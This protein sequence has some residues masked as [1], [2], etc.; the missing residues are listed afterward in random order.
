MLPTWRQIPSVLFLGATGV[1]LYSF[2]F[3][4]GLETITAGRAAL[5]VACIPVCIAAVSAIFYKESFGAVRIAGTLL[6]L[7]G[8]AMVISDGSPLELIRGGIRKGDLYILGC[9]ASWTAYSLGGK[10]TM[11]TLSPLYSVTWSCVFG[12]LLLLPAA[13][14]SGLTHEAMAATPLDWL[15]IVYLGVLATGLAYCWY[16]AAIQSLGAS[17]AGIFIN[18]VPVF[19]V[20]LGFLLLAE[21]IHLSLLVGGM[22]VVGGVWLTNRP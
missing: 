9:V 22:M 5:I 10:A 11:R 8:V 19:A 12:A 14:A 17:R 6:S 13:L 4:N 20:I 18:L 3:F 7:A 1:F 16:Y 21:P 15:C 2:F